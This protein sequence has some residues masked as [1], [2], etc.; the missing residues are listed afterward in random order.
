M[1]AIITGLF[2]LIGSTIKYTLGTGAIFGVLC[3]C[4]KPT[5]ESFALF[6]N[7]YIKGETGNSITGSIISGVVGVMTSTTFHDLV[8]A[9]IA[10]V[11][12][13]ND[14]MPFIGCLGGWYALS[15]SN[16]TIKVN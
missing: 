15:Q 10:E 4:T 14:V 7:N 1:T 12:Y 3:V 8:V 13:K 11:K 16:N 2:S 6:F 9:R 5:E